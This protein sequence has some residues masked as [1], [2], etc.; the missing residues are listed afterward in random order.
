[1]HSNGPI[2]IPQDLHDPVRVATLDASQLVTRVPCDPRAI[3]AAALPGPASRYRIG[4]RIPRS[5]SPSTA[6]TPAGSRLRPWVRN[7]CAAPRSTTMDP[8]LTAPARIHRLRFS[9]GVYCARK[10]VPRGSPAAIRRSTSVSPP[11]AMS[12]SVP[13]RRAV[14][15]ASNLVAIPPSA[16]ALS[17]CPPQAPARHHRSQPPQRSTG[18]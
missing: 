8:L 6:I 17:G 12:T 2:R 14:V 13:A 4:D 18:H 11:L 10:R 1:M 16:Q 3:S 9:G 7:A 5:N 15:A